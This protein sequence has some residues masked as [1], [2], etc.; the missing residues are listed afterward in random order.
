M[1]LDTVQIVPLRG[2]PIFYL[3]KEHLSNNANVTLIP[4]ND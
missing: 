3:D 1:K 4:Q 2:F